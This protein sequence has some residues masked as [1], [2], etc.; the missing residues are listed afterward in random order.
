MICPI[1]SN[2]HL[3]FSFYTSLWGFSCMPFT[4]SSWL[5]ECARFNPRNLLWYTNVKPQIDPQNI[6]SKLALLTLAFPQLRILWSRDARHT[7]SFC[8]NL[9]SIGFFFLYAPPP[10]CLPRT[11][12]WFFLHHIGTSD[13]WRVRA[14]CTRVFMFLT[15]LLLH[16]NNN[17]K[18]SS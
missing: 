7:V 3:F 9:Y 4:F 10:F 15:V 16:K 14:E 17:L 2:V 1:Y 6:C 13:N 18:S 11:H 12:G 5:N 8:N